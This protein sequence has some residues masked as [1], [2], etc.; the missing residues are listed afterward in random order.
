[1]GDL[2]KT[3]GE[4][5]LVRKRTKVKVKTIKGAVLEAM[6]NIAEGSVQRPKSV[7]NERS[8]AIDISSNSEEDLDKFVR[9]RRLNRGRSSAP[10][11]RAAFKVDLVG[12]S[13]DCGEDKLVEK[14]GSRE[15]WEQVK[16]NKKRRVTTPEQAGKELTE[17]TQ[18]EETSG[19]D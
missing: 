3:K 4:K 12:E 5:P 16:G 6:A 18:A 19:G 13:T 7:K 11:I 14:K 2:R 8:L 9:E 1:M 17:E 15:R 10:L